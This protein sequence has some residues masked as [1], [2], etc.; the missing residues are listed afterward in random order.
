MSWKPLELPAACQK[1]GGLTRIHQ[2][3]LM[4]E[5]ESRVRVGLGS[6]HF[7]TVKNGGF[8]QGEWGG[9]ETNTPRHLLTVLDKPY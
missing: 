8:M 2:M 7:Q 1:G 6:Q 9:Q 3:G 4:Q 5:A